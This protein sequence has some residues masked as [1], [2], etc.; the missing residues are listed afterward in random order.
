[1][2][3]LNSL[4]E[5]SSLREK[6]DIEDRFNKP[7]ELFERVVLYKKSCIYDDTSYL[8]EISA[9]YG[10]LIVLIFDIMNPKLVRRLVLN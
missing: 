1:M 8:V 10:K 7:E 4:K 2:R 5:N 3:Y 6:K 9:A